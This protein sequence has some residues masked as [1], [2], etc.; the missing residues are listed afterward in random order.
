MTA[1]SGMKKKTKVIEGVV[2]CL[3]LVGCSSIFGDS[4]SEELNASYALLSA[5]GDSVI[6]VIDFSTQ[7][8]GPDTDRPFASLLFHPPRPTPSRPCEDPFEFGCELKTL[9]WWGDYTV[10]Q[11]GVTVTVSWYPSFDNKL[12]AADEAAMAV[13]GTTLLLEGDWLY[14]EIGLVQDELA[15]LYPFSQ[16]RL[17]YLERSAACAQ[18]EPDL[19]S[20][21]FC[22]N[23][24]F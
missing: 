6:S 9:D 10:D 23:Y 3:L 13:F 21:L 19:R 15:I 14:L 16:S 7:A 5:N 18:A 17:G 2:L 8:D 20:A 12:T 1:I 11:A 22:D 24:G 4:E